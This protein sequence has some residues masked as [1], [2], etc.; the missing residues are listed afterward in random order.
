MFLWC[1]LTFA[2]DLLLT[3]YCSLPSIFFLRLSL[4][5]VRPHVSMD[6]DGYNRKEHALVS[7]VCHDGASMY[8]LARCTDEVCVAHLCWERMQLNL[9]KSEGK[10]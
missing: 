6:R 10:F 5:F 3:S 9:S 2:I 4:L 8:Y 7:F 1:W